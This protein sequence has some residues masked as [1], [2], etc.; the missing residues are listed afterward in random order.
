MKNVFIFDLDGTVI[1]SS[2]RTPTHSDGTLN[3]EKYLELRVPEYIFK[4][5]LLPLARVM[6]RLYDEG[7]YIIICTARIM[8]QADMDFLEKNNIPYHLMQARLPSE[9][10]VKDA[11]L[12]TKKIGKLLNLIQFRKK[13]WFMFDDAKP[14]ISAMRQLGITCLNAKKVNERL[15]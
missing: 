9:D 3:L 14:V 6:R 13:Q 10:R 2:H 1:D 7:H 5:S 4:D 11:T 8:S 15:V 12:K